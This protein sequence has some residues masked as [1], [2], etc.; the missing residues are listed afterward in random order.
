[1]RAQPRGREAQF[2]P[3]HA[4]GNGISIRTQRMA[5]GVIPS[6]FAIRYKSAAG[7]VAGRLRSVRSRWLASALWSAVTGHRFSEATCR[8]RTTANVRKNGRSHGSRQRWGA[9]EV[10]LPCRPPTATSR[11]PKGGENSPHCK[12]RLPASRPPRCARSRPVPSLFG[13]I[14][15]PIFNT[16]WY[17]A[18]AGA[19]RAHG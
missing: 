1:M 17:V 11:L 4:T 16:D 3:P 14:I 2:T 10:S 8:R 12:A 6:V 9:C 15:K 5:A 13:I 7:T 19:L 18:F